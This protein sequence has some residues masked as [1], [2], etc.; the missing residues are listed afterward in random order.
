MRKI[1]ATEFDQ[2]Q[3]LKVWKNFIE[4][5][6]EKAPSFANAIAKYPPQLKDNF[7]VEYHVDNQIVANDLLNVTSMLEFL[8]KELNNNQITL[9]P[10]VAEK[11]TSKSSIYRPGKV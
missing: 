6:Q 9:K 2:E 7:V 1:I 4:F 11:T 5:Y 10:V 8:K 3:L